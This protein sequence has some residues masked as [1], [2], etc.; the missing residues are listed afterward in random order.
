MTDTLGRAVEAL[1]RHA[2][3]LAA[4]R[5]RGLVWLT[6]DADACRQAALALWQAGGW[7]DPLWMAPGAP[8]GLPER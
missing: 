5:W 6:G 7:R 1:R 4:R 3:H 2:G 8:P